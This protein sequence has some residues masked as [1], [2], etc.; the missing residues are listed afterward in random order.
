MNSGRC[1]LWGICSDLSLTEGGDMLVCSADL[2]PKETGKWWGNGM[3]PQGSHCSLS[4]D[5]AMITQSCMCLP[6]ST[7]AVT[8]ALG[9]SPCQTQSLQFCLLAQSLG[10]LQE[11]IK[12][13]HGKP[14]PREHCS[15]TDWC[16]NHT[17]WN[18]SVILIP[19]IYFFFFN[20]H[21]VSSD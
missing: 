18:W 14:H 13:Y 11:E 16:R 12:W 5:P 10:H 4:S 2:L 3:H 6:A 17:F 21:D 9:S 1:A 19:Y 15:F 20:L 7:A 8:P